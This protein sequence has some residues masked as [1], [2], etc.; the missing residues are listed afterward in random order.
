VLSGGGFREYWLNDVP[1]ASLYPRCDHY[2]CATW[3]PY[4]HA[5]LPE[6]VERGLAGGPT[7]C[8]SAAE[9]E[10]RLLEILAAARALIRRERPYLQCVREH[11]D[12]IR[13]HLRPAR[14][15]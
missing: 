6:C 11:Y 12:A 1:F 7:R 14:P 5:M 8:A 9:L 13:R 15:A 2:P 3:T 4:A 10:G